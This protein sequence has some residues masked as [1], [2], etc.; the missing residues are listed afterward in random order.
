MTNHGAREYLT[1]R[2]TAQREA[3]AARRL[4]WIAVQVF[5]GGSM[6]DGPS[7]ETEAV[8]F[9]GANNLNS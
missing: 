3:H 4:K 8:T 6:N 9:A 7:R 1:A 2:I 5:V